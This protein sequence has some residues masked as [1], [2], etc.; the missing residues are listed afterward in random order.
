[1]RGLRF[2]TLAQAGVMRQQLDRVQKLVYGM[3]RN[4]VIFFVFIQ[5]VA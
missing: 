3:K 5:S 1:M 4:R 2:C